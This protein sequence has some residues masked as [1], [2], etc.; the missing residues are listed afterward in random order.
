M[1][2]DTTLY[3]VLDVQPDATAEQIKKAYRRKAIQ[4]HPDKNPNNPGAQSKFQEVSK[5]YKI[6]SEPDL[7]NRY[8]EFGLSKERGGISVDE[9][10]FEMLMAVFGGDSFQ[11]WIGEYSFLKNLMKQTEL[12]E[13]EDDEVGNEQKGFQNKDYFRGAASAPVGSSPLESD[14]TVGPGRTCS[15]LYKRDFTNVSHK[16]GSNNEEISKELN[17]NMYGANS[18][19]GNGSVTCDG[20]FKTGTNSSDTPCEG[21][22]VDVSSNRKDKRHRQKEKFL[23]LE[24]ERREEKKRQIAELA[25]I[26]DKKIKDFQ[27]TVDGGRPKKYIDKLQDEIDKSLKSE[28]FGI[29]LLQLIGKVYRSKANNFLMSQKTYGISRIF[30]GVHEKTKSVKSTFSML[31]SAMNAMSAQKEL[32]KVNLENMDPYERAKLEFLI[33]GKSMGMMWSLNKFELQS[34]LKGVCDKI[35]EDKSVPTDQRISKAKTLLFIA[36]MFCK[37]HR[38]DGD[39]DPA[40][41][42][43][44]DMVLQSKNVRIKT[45]NQYT[46][47]SS[48]NVNNNYSNFRYSSFSATVPHNANSNVMDP[49][50]ST[51]KDTPKSPNPV[52]PH[53]SGTKPFPSSTF[54]SRSSKSNRLFRHSSF[55]SPTCRPSTSHPGSE[56]PSATRTPHRGASMRSGMG[57]F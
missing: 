14:T 15:G 13:E 29:E 38:K 54:T 34:K 10:P 18:G 57:H 19:L 41:S 2:K 3:E 25:I 16:V 48:D 49:Q 35:L 4:T 46:K 28:S 12:F 1:V 50:Q 6:L 9:N 7:K 39:V 37:A 55:R 27:A 56:S 20:Q 32:E 43:F 40:I 47:S 21:F 52:P 11:Q 5:A 17:Q 53:N 45:K 24:K 31:N 26:L 42:E 51:P 44:E 8:D 30:T 23:E 36:D 33:Q 22:S